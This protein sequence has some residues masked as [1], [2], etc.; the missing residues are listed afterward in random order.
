MIVIN[1]KV[2]VRVVKGD[3]QSEEGESLSEATCAGA[4][5]VHS[6]RRQ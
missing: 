3:V 5:H 2:E 4:V 1:Q 6:K